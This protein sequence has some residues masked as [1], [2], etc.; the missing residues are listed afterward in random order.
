MTRTLTGRYVF[1]PTLLMRCSASAR[2]SFGCTSIGSS[3]SSSRKIVPPSASTKGEMRLS[4]APVNDAALVTEERALGERRRDGAAVDDDEGLV[5]AR[6]RLV[7]RLRDELLAGA[8]LARD[9]HG[10][11][12]RRGLAQALEHA[13]HPGARA[14]ER[15]ELGDVGD[16]DLL[17]RVGANSSAVSP[18]TTLVG[19]RR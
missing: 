1:D 4:T 8:R 19:L 5:G 17:G 6:A 9:E 11:L 14:D 7:D 13:A 18:Q 10:E 2:S 3:P 16:V 15:P 12:G